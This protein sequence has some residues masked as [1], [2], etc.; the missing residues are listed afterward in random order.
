VVAFRIDENL[1]FVLQPAEGLRVDDPVSISLERRPQAALILFVV[2]ATARV[3]RAH[4][5]RR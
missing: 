3:V 1:R 5:E 4:C 2:C